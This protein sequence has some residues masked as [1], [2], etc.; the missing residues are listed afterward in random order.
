MKFTSF[1]LCFM[2]TY[3]LHLAEC[4]KLNIREKESNNITQKDEYIRL[5]TI[6]NCLNVCGSV[7]EDCRSVMYFC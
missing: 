4:L 3:F 6:S 5:F 1:Y 7:F 2:Y